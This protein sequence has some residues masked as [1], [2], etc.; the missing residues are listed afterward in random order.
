MQGYANP[1]QIAG[2]LHTRLYA[3]S[4]IVAEID[5]PS[6]RAVF[7]NLDA[8]MASQAVTFTVIKRLRDLFGNSTYSESNIILSGT[9]TH[10]GPAGYLQYIAYDITGLG[11]VKETF[12]AL[13]DGIVLSIVRAHKGLQPGSLHVSV[14][15]LT[16]ANVNRSPTAYT[17]NPQEE[18]NMYE[19]DVDKNMTLLRINDIQGKGL[20]AFSWYPVHGTSV[21]NTNTLIN[22]DNKGTASLLME[23]SMG[24]N[25]IA[26][27][28]QANVG[29]TS[30]NTLGAFCID[31]G[32]PCDAVHS[33]CNGRVQNCIGRGPAW[34]DNFKSCEIIGSKQSDKA[35]ELFDGKGLSGMSLNLYISFWWQLRTTNYF[36]AVYGSI[37]SMHTF[38]D[39]RD[40]HV[41]ESEHTRAGKT[42][43]P[44]MGF[45]FAA[46]TTDGPGA[47]DFKQS[48]TNGTIFWKI[49]RDFITTPSKEQENCHMPK[50]ILLDV[51]KSVY[52]F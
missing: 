45:S 17:Q 36:N 7:V 14:G 3:R 16:D 38:I 19:Y 4:F 41:K 15:L 47:F 43:K 6:N 27:F 30:P 21:N 28:C 12:D 26:A 48:D 11:F 18:R 52:E 40:I 35:M 20:G 13:V 42:C 34:P 37:E 51:G 50:P 24:E 9:H 44:A 49:V 1:E 32:L 46:G 33:T 10:S 25:F 2:G 23:K 39:M 29:D 8:C 31:T 5:N 22:G